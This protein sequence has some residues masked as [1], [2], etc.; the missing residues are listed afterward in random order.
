MP[1]DK[2][3]CVIG[4][5]GPLRFA[6]YGRKW[7]TT[8]EEAVGHAESLLRNESS[9]VKNGEPDEVYVVEVKK[10]VMTEDR[11]PRLLTV[12]PDEY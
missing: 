5:Q 6:A 9:K 10:I 2:R 1:M 7:M 4:H 3:F 11:R 12:S 8:E